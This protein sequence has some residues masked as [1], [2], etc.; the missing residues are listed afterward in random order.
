MGGKKYLVLLGFFA[1]VGACDIY[2]DCGNYRAYVFSE[3]KPLDANIN[4]DYN[5][6]DGGGDKFMPT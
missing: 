2:R 4:R 5:D 1:V 3:Y 6:L